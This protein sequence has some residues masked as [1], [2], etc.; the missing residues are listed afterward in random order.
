MNNPSTE[1]KT[2]KNSWWILVSIGMFAFMSNLDSSIVNIAMP[3]MAKQLHVPMNQIE[4]VVSSYLIV[5]TALLLFFGKLGDIYGK[6]KVFRIGTVIFLLGSF[7]SG[8]QINFPFLLVGR[9]IQGTGAAMTLSNTYGI[10]TSTFGIKERG[11]AMGFVGTFVALGAIAGPGLG[12]LILSKLP[13]GYIFWVNLPIGIIA[14]TLGAV[15][16]P[17]AFQT[18]PG[19]IDWLGFVNFSLMIIGLF[20]GVFIGQEVGYTQPVPLGLFALGI[21]TLWGFFHTEKRA[22][23]PLMPLSLFKIKPFSY[24]LGAAVLIFLSNFFTVVIVPFYLEDARQLS[25]GQAGALL[26][27]F[28]VVMVFSGPFGGWLA[29][30]FSP[31][32]IASIGLLIVA[33]AQAM[34]I[35]LTLTS[36]MWVYVIITVIMAFG[37][38]LFQSPN[39]DIV[40]SVVPK[41][42]L[43][44]AGSLNALARNVGMI[45]GTALS[46][47]ALFIAMGIKAGFHVTNYLPKQP[48]VFIFGMHVAFAVSLVIILGAWGLS[49]MQGRTVKPGDLK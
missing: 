35:F 22:E 9:F 6:V 49:I 31:A 2:Q 27:I 26:I 10:T 18:V 20:L 38:G 47:S 7:L 48:E 12:G 19:S 39:S 41:N 17:K 28:P 13:W 3:I 21:V 4:W 30:H 15:V 29:D 42:S 24:G 16:M 37:T 32:T 23:N 45:S 8:L 14:I 36:P 46:T 33:V 44:S 5:L 25:A 1:T 11:R 40:M 43:G 34:Y